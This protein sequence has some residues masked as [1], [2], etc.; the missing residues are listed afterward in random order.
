MKWQSGR[1]RIGTWV[2]LTKACAAMLDRNKSNFFA[3]TCFWLIFTSL[4]TVVPPKKFDSMYIKTISNEEVLW[5][6][7]CCRI[8]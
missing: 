7:S 3:K 2:V 1:W 5:E 6:I 4:C 8:V